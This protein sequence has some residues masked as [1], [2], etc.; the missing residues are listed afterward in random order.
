MGES[1]QTDRGRHPLGGLAA[2]LAGIGHDSPH[3]DQVER[4]DRRGLS[5]LDAQAVLRGARLR[6]SL[7]RAPEEEPAITQIRQNRWA[8]GGEN[9]AIGRETKLVD[10]ALERSQGR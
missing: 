9:P 4:D 10:Q 6:Q 2:R 1:D 5:E 8:H 7:G 3:L